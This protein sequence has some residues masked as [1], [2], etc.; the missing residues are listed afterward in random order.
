MRTTLILLLQLMVAFQMHARTGQVADRVMAL[1]EKGVQFQPVQ[2]FSAMPKTAETNKL[3]AAA[4]KEGTVLQ[5]ND[6]ATRAI[7]DGN[8]PMYA[9]L[10]LPSTNGTI[11]LDLVRTQITTEDFKVNTGSGTGAAYAPGVHYRGMVHGVAGSI[12][13]IS[14][15]DGEVMG[16]IN[17]GAEEFVL[18]RFE[19]DRSG[20]HVIYRTRDL[21]GKQSFVC[22]TEGPDEPYRAD[23]L[24]VVGSDRTTRC[25][26]Y[27]WEVNYDIYLNK[28]SVALAAN[29]ATGLFNQSA[30]LFDNDGIDVT[31]SE[32]FV[33][34]VASPFTGANSSEQLSNFRTTRTTFNGDLAHLL[35][36]NNYGGRAYLNVICGSTN[37]HAYS[38]IYS[39]Y[40]SV[41]T[42]SWSVSV[43][44]HEQGHN[45]GSSHTHGCVWN[46]N[47]TAIDGCGPTYNAIYSEGGCAVGPVPTGTGGTIMSYCHLLGGVGINFNNG[48]G[49]QPSAVMVNAVNGATCLAVCGNSCDAPGNL[50]ATAI[51]VNSANLSWAAL[52]AT[53]YTLRW[54]PVVGS[55]WTEVTGI[56]GNTYALA[57][58]SQGTA[59]EFQ[60]LSVCGATSSAYSASRTF[61]TAV[62]CPDAL[63]P[64][65]TTGT[66]P[67][68][69]L[70]T[71]ISALIATN[72]DA[73][74]Y[75]FTL[76]GTSTLNLSLSNVAGDYDLRLLDNTGAE[77]AISQL[78]GTSNEY[79]SYPNAPAATYYIHVFGYNGAFS[80]TQCYSLNVSAYGVQGCGRP[81]GVLVSSITYQSATVNWNAVQGASTYAVRRSLNGQGSWSTWSNLSGT[82]FDLS[83]LAW[84]TT[85]DVQVSANC[86]GG[87]QG[88][89]NSE[90]S[91]TVTFTTLPAPCEV[92]PPIS[93]LV[94]I[95]LAGP[96]NDS[97]QLMSDSLRVKGL[98]PIQEPYSALG[99]PVDGNASTTAQILAVTGSNA[100]V[101]WVL[102]ELRDS[103]DPSIIVETRAALVLRNGDIVGTDGQLGVDFCSE[104]GTYHV[105]VRHRNHLGIMSMNA[106]AL[107]GTSPW[108]DFRASNIPTYGTNSRKAV[109]SGR[110]GMWSGNTTGN[111]PGGTLGQVEVK[112]TG[113]YND[114]DMILV[115]IGGNVASNVISGYR[116]E[117]CNMDGRVKYTGAGN[118]R[119]MILVNI[120]GSVATNI[121]IEQ[122]P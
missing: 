55:T 36:L 12:A 79:I 76:A 47:G 50:T 41:P 94:G 67:L 110:M 2:L 58:L 73:D 38:G 25:V 86:S 39:N 102:V 118:D 93:I 6:R 101:D 5:L 85:Y 22:A 88:G 14:I 1:K 26:R 53:T 51:T 56:T 98:V 99:Y 71:N 74:Y 30:I 20:K 122:L 21:L 31:L 66:A 69:T 109:G 104:P 92:S 82:T 60:V 46:G 87:T 89:T 62:P 34:D 4:I 83:G 95:E 27:Y 91:A 17:D 100:V 28:G 121:V 11:I 49:P 44:T 81:D 78:G 42:Y 68:I 19:N 23:Q 32:L 13:A 119:D 108:F 40:S 120:G 112:F 106:V 52:G 29:Y 65:N 3:W 57:G 77:L 114:R 75:R 105:A 7:I 9:T 54:K 84:N 18:G 80:A 103:S 64:N 43:V 96:Y 113:S 33:W 8:A 70:P 10:E 45:L 15:F 48:F 116:M 24:A 63:E 107:A 111:T 59:Y 90:Y 97:D 115:A 117:D 35:D 61:T 37:R 16:L 72:A